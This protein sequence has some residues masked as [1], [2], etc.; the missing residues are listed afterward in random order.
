MQPPLQQQLDRTLH[1]TFGLAH[2]RP[3]Q[4]DVIQAILSGQDVLA[5]M[6]TGAGKSLCYQLPALLRP[7]ATLVISPLI[8]LMK[9]QAD[10]L[11]EL[12][13]E[14]A[15]LNSS[16]NAS[17]Q[18]AA[19]D[20]IRHEEE[21]FIYTTPERLAQPE[22]QDMLRHTA[23]DLVVVDEAHCISQWGHDFR[24][25]FMRIGQVL[26]ALGRPQVLALTATATPEVIDDIREQLHRPQMRVM[27]TGILRE[28]LLYEVMPVV[29]DHEKLD[30]IAQLAAELPGSGIVYTATIKQAESVYA[31]LC[32]QGEAVALYHGKLGARERD[33]M[34]DR[35]MSGAVRIMIATN[36]FGM[37]ID[38]PDIRFII[39]YA[40]PGSLEAYYQESGRAGRDQQAARC[41]LLYDPADKRTQQY[42]LSGRYPHRGQLQ[43]VYEALAQLGAH[44]SPV[45]FAALKETSGLARGRL[46]AILAAMQQLGLVMW[47]ADDVRLQQVGHEPAAVAALLQQYE[48]Q[49]K[50]DRQKLKKM[51]FYAQTAFCRWKVLTDYFG[52][53]LPFQDCGQCDN[54]RHPMQVPATPAHPSTAPDM[55]PPAFT[56]GE[57]VTLPQYGEGMVESSNGDTVRVTFPNGETHEFKQ[58]Y[59]QRA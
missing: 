1:E 51:L 15:L 43:A 5:V 10:K 13:V 22:F 55:L 41:I 7:G 17:A 56:R 33:D 54:C 28:N 30:R 29:S 46:E 23:L 8:A 14:T 58:A 45:A 21:E 26:D 47:T 11:E 35:F 36:A 49:A 50:K 52:D 37:G 20:E 57:H 38:K 19:L 53:A 3:A 27:H 24:P 31:R 44:A 32:D 18:H 4:K 12:G 40:I 39:H 6:P 34:Q 42:F 48:Q 9:D 59:V 2:L 25:A 16:Q